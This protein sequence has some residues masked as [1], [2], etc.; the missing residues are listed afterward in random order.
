MSKIEAKT[1]KTIF[2]NVLLNACLLPFK[3]CFFG[4]QLAFD[5]VYCAKLCH[6]LCLRH[7]LIKHLDKNNYQYKYME[8]NSFYKALLCSTA[9]V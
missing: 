1:Q 7:Q 9:S 6:L 2:A 8:S 3:Y 5:P 4:G